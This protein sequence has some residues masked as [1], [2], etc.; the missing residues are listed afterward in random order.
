MVASAFLAESV[1]AK[2][3]LALLNRAIDRIENELNAR[4]PG[5]TLDKAEIKSLMDV[6][7]CCAN[8]EEWDRVVDMSSRAVVAGC[9]VNASLWFYR[10]WI[11]GL[12]HANDVGN[13]QALARHLMAKR[14]LSSD[15]LSITLLA[16][17]YS[18]RQAYAKVLAS[19]IE[20]SNT[21]SSIAGMAYAS[22]CCESV[23]KKTRLYG[24]RLYRSVTQKTPNDFFNL[25]AFYGYCLESE[26]HSAAANVLKDINTRFPMAIE[27]YWVSARMAFQE[28][29]WNDCLNALAHILNTNAAN[30]EANLFYAH[31]LCEAG[32]ALAAREFLAKTRQIFSENDFDYNFVFAK[33][34]ESL[35][36]RY[37]GENF[38]NAA[39]SHLVKAK[40]SAKK[41]KLQVAD[42]HM[43][44]HDLKAGVGEEQI[45]KQRSVSSQ[46]YWLFTMEPAEVRSLLTQ[47]K[48]FLK[49]PAGMSQND[50]VFFAHKNKQ[51]ETRVEGCFKVTSP[52]VPD[53]TLG[54]VVR[55]DDLKVF[56]ASLPLELDSTFEECTDAFGCN[57]FSGQ[58]KA[59][60]YTMTAEWAENLV[61]RVE[62]GDQT[63]AFT[64]GRHAS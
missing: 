29:N 13:L 21:R 28:K 27:P 30:E 38:K 12:K 53:S 24:L 9:G 32:D 39:I 8:K 49:V 33:I 45:G 48:S 10:A 55:I 64:R 42:I 54:H 23:E 43:A 34:N 60:F 61:T 40:Q 20:K 18:G 35:H 2:N 26:C 7:V 56:E 47:S 41:V 44:L 63:R 22:Y 46:N 17:T 62:Q 11:E 1:D 16:L 3:D 14:S 4:T 5:R 52:T 31:A 36:S 51:G 15:F 37:K 57:N 59:L 19:H 50:V 58:N 25:H 6:I